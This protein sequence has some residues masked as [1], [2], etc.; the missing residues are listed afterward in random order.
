[1]SLSVSRR[2]SPVLLHVLFGGNAL[3]SYSDKSQA[4]SQVDI[5]GTLNQ[6]LVL[7]EDVTVKY[8]I[9]YG[10]KSTSGRRGKESF[11]ADK[12]DYLHLQRSAQ[13]ALRVILHVLS[14]IIPR[15]L[16]NGNLMNTLTVEGDWA[17]G[18]A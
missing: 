16:T 8:N 2:V 12:G 6:I 15:T 4:L 1:M 11:L 9:G 13:I 3:T 14:S 10:F 5:L 18:N 17:Q 7:K